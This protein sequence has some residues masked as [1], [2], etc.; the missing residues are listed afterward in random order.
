MKNMRE[1][2]LALLLKQYVTPLDA[3]RHCGCMSLSQRCGEFREDWRF[4]NAASQTYRA[5][6][7]RPPLIV[8]H[9]VKLPNGKRCKAYRAIK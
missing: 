2:L 6:V 9:W 4:W 3:L 8:D 1:R 5:R 7:P